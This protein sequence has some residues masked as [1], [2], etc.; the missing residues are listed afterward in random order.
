ME[1]TLY[2]TNRRSCYLLQYHLVVVTKYRQPVITGE[3]KTFLIQETIEL[4]EQQ[5]KCQVS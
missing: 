4:F 3:L 2:N 1:K 5:W